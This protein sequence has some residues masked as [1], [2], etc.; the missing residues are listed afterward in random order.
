M[1][2]PGLVVLLLLAAARRR[3]IGYFTGF[4]LAADVVLFVMWGLVADGSLRY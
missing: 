4:F 1:L 3:T 2:G